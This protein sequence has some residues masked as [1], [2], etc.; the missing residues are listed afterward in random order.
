MTGTFPSLIENEGFDF[1][2]G[3][4]YVTINFFFPD[5]IPCLLNRTGISKRIPSLSIVT[6]V[7]LGSGKKNLTRRRVMKEEYITEYECSRIIGIRAAQISMSAPV[8]I[9]IPVALPNKFM[10]F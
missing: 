7:I 9:E 4:T 10:Y 8:L 3:L 6:W 5:M 1:R 2:S